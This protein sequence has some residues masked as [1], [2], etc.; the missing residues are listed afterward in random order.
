MS[1]LVN[2]AVCFDDLKYQ[3]GLGNHFAT[4]AL[5]G[6]LP[7]GQNSPQQCAFGLYAE[8]LTGTAF[9]C[10]RARN[11]RSW[12]YKI[13]PSVGH[14]PFQEISMPLSSMDLL[15]NNPNQFR[16]KPF[17][18]PTEGEVTFVNGLRIVAGAGDPTLKT[19]LAIYVYG[20]NTSMDKT[21]FYDSDGDMLIVPQKGTLRIQ[22]EMGLMV[23]EPCEICVVPRGI[24]FSVHVDGPSRGYVQEIFSGHFEIPSLGPI[25]SNGLAN[26]RDFQIPVA[27]YQDDDSSFNLVNKFGGQYFQATMPNTPYDTV[28]WHGNYYP[29]KYDLRKFN[30]MNSVTYD[31]PDPSIYTVLT[32]PTTEPGVAVCDFVI[33]PPRWMVMENSFRPPWYHR[34][35]MSEFMGMIYGKYDAKVGF[36]AGGASL[37]NTMTAHGPD[38]ETF[39]KAST[40]ELK[41]QYFDAGL[42]FMFESTFMYK[43]AST[44]LT[45]PN[46]EKDYQSC[47]EGLPKKFPDGF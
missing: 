44:A 4:E 13:R 19:G 22:T 15:Q 31:H 42:A 2:N 40:E 45:A 36:E 21:A 26:P 20:I 23:V 27:N 41:P 46:L 3:D 6:A 16:W 37:H 38:G 11:F 35:T 39:L 47:W 25:G 12:Q 8:Q 18:I 5:K 24:K 29:Y 32:C 10:P 1:A 43:V 30:C 7:V 28:A 17:D 14:G 9:T 34:N 33:F